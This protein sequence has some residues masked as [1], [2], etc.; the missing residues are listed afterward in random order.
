MGYPLIYCD[1]YKIVRG[2]RVD[3]HPQVK[4]QFHCVLDPDSGDLQN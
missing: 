2:T 4:T 3:Q 1:E